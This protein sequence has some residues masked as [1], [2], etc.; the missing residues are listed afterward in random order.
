MVT[1]VKRLFAFG[2]RM[3][4]TDRWPPDR[5][6]WVKSD[7]NMWMLMVELNIRPTTW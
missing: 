1:S 6:N 7:K 3:E 4:R 2:L 5:P